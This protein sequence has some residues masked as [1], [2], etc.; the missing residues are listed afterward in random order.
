MISYKPIYNQTTTP[1]T[2]NKGDM[3]IKAIGTISYQIYIYLENIWRPLLGGGVYTVEPTDD[4]HYY[5]II[6]DTAQPSTSNLQ[7]GWFWYN[8]TAK[9]L[10]I[11]NGSQFISLLAI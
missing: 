11:Y 3:W 10:Y 8:E 1:T 6:F 4:I 7:T 2:A 9:E 5:N